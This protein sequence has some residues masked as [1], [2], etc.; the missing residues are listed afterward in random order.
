MLMLPKSSEGSKNRGVG[1]SEEIVLVWSALSN[2]RTVGEFLSDNFLDF[3]HH[4]FGAEGFA[5][6]LICTLG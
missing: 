3:A 1:R 6:V 5:D 4:L 2:E